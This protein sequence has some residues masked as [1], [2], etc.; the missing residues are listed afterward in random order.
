M[1][2][3]CS[4]QRG[5]LHF[6]VHFIRGRWEGWVGVLGWGELMIAGIL[7][8]GKEVKIGLQDPFDLIL[9]SS[10]ARGGAWS[11]M[12]NNGWLLSLG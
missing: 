10:Q 12:E 6:P 7:I 2:M 4:F 9:C 1:S 5:G 3:I 8:R 11:H